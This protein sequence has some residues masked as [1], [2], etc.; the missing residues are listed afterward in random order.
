MSS[1]SSSSITR[2]FLP[3]TFFDY[4]LVSGNSRLKQGIRLYGNRST[5]LFLLRRRVLLAALT[6]LAAEEASD[7]C[8]HSGATIGNQQLDVAGCTAAVVG[9]EKIVA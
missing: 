4:S 5:Y 1:S 9:V 2:D 8:R 7:I 6:C 3:L